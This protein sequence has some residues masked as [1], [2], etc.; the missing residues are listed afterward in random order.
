MNKKIIDVCCGG[1]MFYFDKHDE[2]VL[3]QDN[4]NFETVLCDGRTFKVQP[5]VIG[6]FTKMVY[7]DDT[8]DMVIFDPPHLIDK[9]DGK[10]TGWQFQKYGSLPPKEWRTIIKKGFAECFRILK[11]EGFLIF[12]WNEEDVVVSEI[13]KLTEQKPIIGHKSGKQQKTHWILFQK[14]I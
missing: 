7:K 2:R 3:F 1:K 10:K 13:L 14:N 4:R 11:N 12:K 6:D 8:F 5:D 9:T